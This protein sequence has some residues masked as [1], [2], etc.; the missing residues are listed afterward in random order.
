MENEEPEEKGLE[1]REKLQEK[2]SWKHLAISI[3]IVLAVFVSVFLLFSLTKD[4]ERPLTLDELHQLNYQ[5]ELDEEQGYIWNG[6]SFVNVG[7]TWFVT[8]KKGEN[9]FSIPLHYG[10]REVIDVPMIRRNN[11][12]GESEDFYFTFDPDDP[13]MG[14]ITLA[15]TEIGV[16]LAQVFLIAPKPACT[17][18]IDPACEGVAIGSCDLN[19]SVFYV[20][21]A[22]KPSVTVEDQCA[23]IEGD[24]W[25]L[26][27]AADRFLLV[28]YGLM[29]P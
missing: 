1:E 21:T 24:E 19:G 17:S 10:P 14:F 28:I 3:V 2:R 7:N 27:R 4:D 23:I 12:F 5:G 11:T 16:T 18:D 22:D 25:D 8:I 29:E 15:S 20:R 9:L 6:N 13:K 26:V